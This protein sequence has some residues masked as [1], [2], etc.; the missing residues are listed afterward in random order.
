M[1]GEAIR[2]L[3]VLRLKDALAECVASKPSRMIVLHERFE[4]LLWYVCKCDLSQL[5]ITIKEESR[6]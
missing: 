4:D 1:E 2:L 6:R 3:R 5:L